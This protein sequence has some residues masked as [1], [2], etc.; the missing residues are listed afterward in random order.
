[1]VIGGGGTSVPSNTLF[2]DP[3]Q[4]RVITSVGAPEPKT[5]KRP[6]VYVKEQAPWSAVRNA[7][8]SYGFAART[9][10]PGSD[11]GAFTTIKITYYDG[12]GQTV[13]WPRSKPSR[14][15]APV[16]TRFAGHVGIIRRSASARSAASK[17]AD[18]DLNCWWT[19]PVND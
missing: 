17:G 18:H 4:C 11:P 3:P 19:E 6:P 9:V 13:S 2:F 8:H 15:A 7:A 10:D 1:M 5:G 14:C 12:W 16:A